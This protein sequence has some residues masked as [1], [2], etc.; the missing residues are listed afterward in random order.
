MAHS[1]SVNTNAVNY[2]KS[3]VY[4]DKKGLEL[5]LCLPIAN[6]KSAATGKNTMKTSS[7]GNY[8]SDKDDNFKYSF[9]VCDKEMNKRSK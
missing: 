4:T 1:N 9:S 5:S 3:K 6:E 8:S 2:Y 7:G